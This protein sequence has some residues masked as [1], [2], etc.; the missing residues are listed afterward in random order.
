MTNQRLL[1]LAHLYIRRSMGTLVTNNMLFNNP[2]R[3]V[4]LN[5]QMLIDL[6]FGRSPLGRAI[7]YIFFVSHC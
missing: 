2:L 4:H 7:R 6:L 5:T 1:S 3:Y